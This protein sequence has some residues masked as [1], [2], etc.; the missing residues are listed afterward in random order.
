[1]INK[2]DFDV[3]KLAEEINPGDH[4]YSYQETILYAKWVK[5]E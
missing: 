5:N 2:W 3:D 4:S 1:M